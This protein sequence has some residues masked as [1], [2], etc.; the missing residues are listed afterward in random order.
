M[1]RKSA[2]KSRAKSEAGATATV[3]PPATRK[4]R[5]A[6]KEQRRAQLI[7]AT[8]RCIARKGLS[9]TTMADVTRSA[10]LSMGIVNL[11][12]QT[13]EKLLIETLRFVAEEYKNSWDGI[14]SD[15]DLSPAEKVQ[16]IIEQDFSP[17]ISQPDKLAVWFAFW[18]ESRSRPTYRNICNEAD[19][20]TSA[21]MQTLCRQLGCKSR[22]RAE[23][24]ATGYTA[25]ADGL[26]LDLL[27]T[28]DDMDRAM[29]ARICRNYMASFFPEHFKV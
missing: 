28:P 20:Q 5:S 25:L 9:G 2:V 26:W 24:I 7:K 18:G 14:A 6:S 13:K 1:P 17:G 10:G 3:S 21:S 22:Q 16:A 27:V 29:A 19:L 23:L 4:R 11:H 15:P 12:F 8:I